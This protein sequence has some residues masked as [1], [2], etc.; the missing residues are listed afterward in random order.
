[1]RNFQIGNQIKL[2]LV[3]DM[4]L[5]GHRRSSSQQPIRTDEINNQVNKLD[6]TNLLKHNMMLKSTAK[7]IKSTMSVS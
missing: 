6:L 1:M 3:I 2:K 7:L 5:L 4:A